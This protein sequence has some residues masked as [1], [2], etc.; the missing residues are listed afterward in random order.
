MDSGGMLMALSRKC[1]EALSN[2]EFLV[3]DLK[4]RIAERDAEIESLRAQL[5]KC[6][7]QLD[8]L[9]RVVESLQSVIQDVY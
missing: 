3:D 1:A 2:A 5:A 9:Q 7:I 6:N 8:R 4:D